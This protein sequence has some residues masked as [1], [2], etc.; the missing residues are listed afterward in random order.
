MKTELKPMFA[1]LARIVTTI[2]TFVLPTPSRNCLKEKNS[3]M[4]GMLKTSIR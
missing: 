3:I 1:R 4:K 2:S